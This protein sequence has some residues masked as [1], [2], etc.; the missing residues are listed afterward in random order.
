[1]HIQ[2]TR[3]AKH[4]TRL[5]KSPRRDMQRHTH[6]TN[7]A[8]QAQQDTST[9]RQA[10]QD[11]STPLYTS[12]HGVS[13]PGVSTHGI[14]RDGGKSITPPP[15]VHPPGFDPPAQSQLE[16][17]WVSQ[18][19]AKKLQDSLLRTSSGSVVMLYA[20]AEDRTGAGRGDRPAVVATRCIDQCVGEPKDRH[21]K[22]VLIR[23]P[24]DVEVGGEVIWRR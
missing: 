15:A 17:Q 10:Q 16:S 9:P 20:G 23:A 18:D 5:D 11:T 1:M 4:K 6:T 13:P 7:T 14:C 22:V 2:G 8:R 19:Q 12:G 24:L 21:L 3:N